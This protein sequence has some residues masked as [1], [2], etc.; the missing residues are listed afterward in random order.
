M[1]IF[2]NK[3]FMRFQGVTWSLQVEW[4][5]GGNCK[6]S[7]FFLLFNGFRFLVNLQNLKSVLRVVEQNPS[8]RS[9]WWKVL[10]LAWPETF[11]RVPF[12]CESN[13]KV[14]SY[15]DPRKSY[16]HFRRWH[17][18]FRIS[19][20]G[21]NERRITRTPYQI[22]KSVVKLSLNLR[23]F[24]ALLSEVN[25]LENAEWNNTLPFSKN[26]FCEYIEAEIFNILRINLGLS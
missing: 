23:P 2:I 25:R 24:L 10:L 7:L 4:N 18:N 17:V 15:P 9:L 16:S 8:T 26:M 21:V 12:R 19:L 6:Q 5:K 14:T 20:F 3:L 1:N 13:T 11:T 22:V